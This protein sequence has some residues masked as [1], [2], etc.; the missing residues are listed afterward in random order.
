M[1]FARDA[2]VYW[3]QVKHSE[4]GG[5]EVRRGMTWFPHIFFSTHTVLS[6]NLNTCVIIQRHCRSSHKCSVLEWLAKNAQRRQLHLKK[7]GRKHHH[8]NSGLLSLA[9]KESKLS[10]KI[11]CKRAGGMTHHN[12]QKLDFSTPAGVIGNSSLTPGVGLEDVKS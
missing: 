10:A 9:C 3:K 4:E 1:L 2:F 7:E 12:I 8:H 5:G 11:N 6:Q